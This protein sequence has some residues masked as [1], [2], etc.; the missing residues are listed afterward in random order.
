MKKI[1]ASL[2][3]VVVGC[4]AYAA[5]DEPE[6]LAIYQYALYVLPDAE[7]DPV[8]TVRRLVA[9]KYTGFSV[10]T[11]VDGPP[12]EPLLLLTMANDVQAAYAPPDMESIGYFGR[13][14][15]REQALAVQDSQQALIVDFAYPARLTPTAFP[16]ALNLLAAIA[17]EH[18]TLI[19][20]EATREIFTLDAWRER[21]IDTW[22]DGVP[23][24]EDHTTIHA[25]RNGDYVRAITLGM[26]KFGLPDI[27]VNDFGWSNN[28]SV[29]S[30]INLVTQTLIEGGD[31]ND[32]FSLDID[33]NAI[34]NDE[35]RESLLA[36]LLDNAEARLRLPFKPEDP[37]EGDPENFLLEVRFDTE[38]GVSIHE[39]Q[40]ILLGKLFGSEDSITYVDH[41]E[42][43]LA[44]SEAARAKLP[45]LRTDFNAGLA[46]GE[47]IYVKAPF[48][49][50]DGGNEWMWVEVIQWEDKAIR[51]LLQ[52]DPFH[53]PEL[54]AGAEV[55]VDMD[56]VF[57]YI[58]QF[59]DGTGEGN[60]TGRI[61]QRAQQ[62]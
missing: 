28:R 16:D 14:L 10:V 19:W 41:D 38:P 33:I 49:T 5:D 17:A 20:D 46:P 30:L 8:A 32:D 4:N 2:L 54:K 50:T 44:A 26:A 35:V 45:Q 47:F 36:S 34:K 22:N 53:V 51:G 11:E 23:S 7:G 52:N 57:D 42:E 58:R 40:E 6:R 27:V 9:E 1:I 12:T 48:T 25:Y 3:A 56:E 29:G 60:E 15:S 37:E 24:S 55:A 59:A 31:F 18:D 13:G 39:Q 62:Q 61:M 43:L 21:R